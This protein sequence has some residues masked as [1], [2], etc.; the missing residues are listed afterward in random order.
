MNG[1]NLLIVDNDCIALTLSVIQCLGNSHDINIHVVSVKKTLLPVFKYSR[2]IKSYCYVPT[3][4]D[5]QISE[6]I[7]KSIHSLKID[8]LF[9]IDEKIT[10][11]IAERID[12]FT[13]IVNLPPIP[14]QHVL[15]LVRNKWLL[16]NWLFKNGLSNY[17]PILYSKN[18]YPCKDSI[19]SRMPFLIKPCWGAGGK[20]ISYIK[21][22]KDWSVFKIDPSFGEDGYLLQPFI[23]GYDIDISAIVD[24]G[25]ILTFTIQRGCDASEQFKFSESI[26][27]V[28]NKSV[29]DKAQ[30]VFSTLKYSGVAHLDLRYDF[31]LKSYE[32]IDFNARYWSTLLGSH[33]VGINFPYLTFKY[34][35]N[36]Q[37]EK[38]PY[39]FKKFISTN[40]ILKF[41]HNRFKKDKKRRI[42][43]KQTRLYY[44]LIDPIPLLMNIF[45]FSLIRFRNILRNN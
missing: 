7:E 3:E 29:Y 22:E 27:F 21:S 34:I 2:Y 13:R 17:K 36:R 24:K 30:K 31:N 10:R 42:S 28:E 33:Y 32:L 18:T 20:G 38:Q 43:L 45:N 5:D 15:D 35:M 1:T 4:N 39:F 19:I 14:D 41:L 25:K 23:E 11:I 44:S 37:I 9:P 8:I 40:N 16:Y 6:A 26:E 12:Y